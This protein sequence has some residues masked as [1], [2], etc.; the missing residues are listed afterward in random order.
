MHP[1]NLLPRSLCFSLAFLI[2]LLSPSIL[3]TESLS[4]KIK[5]FIQGGADT[6]FTLKAEIRNYAFFNSGYTLIVQERDSIRKGIN[7]IFTLF[8]ADGKMVWDTVLAGW[9]DCELT[10]DVIASPKVVIRGW[11]G[12][13]RGATVI[14]S[15]NG[16]RLAA[17][18][19]VSVLRASPGGVY[20]YSIPSGMEPNFLNVYD[21]LG[22]LLWSDTTHSE[23]GFAVPLTDSLLL[24]RVWGELQG[25]FLLA[26]KNGK[27][28]MKLTGDT[29]VPPSY[30]GSVSV[31]QN[32]QFFALYGT[33]YLYEPTISSFTIGGSLLWEANF[34]KTNKKVLETVLSPDGKFLASFIIHNEKPDKQGV[35]LRDNLA[36]GKIIWNTEVRKEGMYIGSAWN[37]I[38]V[39]EELIT[40]VLPSGYD[41]YR[42]QGLTPAT[43]TK[44]IFFDPTNGSI[45]DSLTV[46]GFLTQVHSRSSGTQYFRVIYNEERKQ[47]VV[48]RNR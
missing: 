41:Y 36:K 15:I 16:N 9:D 42:Y 35:T 2:F 1:K 45:T 29:I 30:L 7:P 5:R 26:P 10:A 19:E 25:L 20:F 18:K 24:Y 4:D 44:C 14:Y 6:L 27:R 21:S 8:D 22:T 39:F 47:I 43:K 33:P 28:K 34:G 3:R 38:S 17:V 32:G 31:A 37:S 40:L 11:L 13:G 46:S 12:E 23:F 48:L